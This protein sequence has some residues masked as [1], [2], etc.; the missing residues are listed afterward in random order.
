MQDRF[1]KWVELSPLRRATAA[2]HVTD[3]IV[4]WHGCP[5]QVIS[6]NGR[7][8]IGRPMK[9]LLQE[10]GIE[11]RTTPAYA[12]HCNP[13]ERTN[14]TIKTM[15]AQFVGNNHRLWD[16][17]LGALQFAYYTDPHDAG[18]SPAYLNHG[19]ELEEPTGLRDQRPVPATAPTANQRRLEEA[20]EVVRTNLARAFNRQERHYNLRRRAW[21]PALGDTV[22]KREH[23]LSNKGQGFNAKLAPKYAGPFEVRK[24]HSP[25]IVDIRDPQG[26]WHRRVHVQDLKPGTR[27]A[28]T[29]QTDTEDDGDDRADDNRADDDRADDDRADD[30]QAEDTHGNH[31]T[32]ESDADDP[33]R[34]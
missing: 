14:R 5:R 28:A 24:I 10:L 23:L 27:G 31:E 8:F 6:D 11:H 25:V 30:D 15:V 13:V 7:P 4:Y 34:S 22:W 29:E 1:T 26:K 3:R 18:Y 32:A 9:A 33:A 20:Y 16:Q 17:Q 21:K 2:Q 19:R 12:P